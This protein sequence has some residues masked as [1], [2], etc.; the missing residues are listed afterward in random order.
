MKNQ[1]THPKFKTWETSIIQLDT[2]VNMTDKAVQLTGEI[3]KGSVWFPLSIV[4]VIDQFEV[5]VP[6]WLLS[7]KGLQFLA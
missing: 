4:N 6:T 7:K 5:E 2:P 1:A 3:V